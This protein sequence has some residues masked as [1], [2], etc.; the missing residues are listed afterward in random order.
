M[1]IY[2]IRHQKIAQNQY[3]N[4]NAQASLQPLVYKLN[5]KKLLD[6]QEV[7]DID[8]DDKKST[9]PDHICVLAKDLYLYIIDFVNHTVVEKYDDER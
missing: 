6:N 5:M 2:Q 3:N 4:H 8:L 7:A 9:D 1:F